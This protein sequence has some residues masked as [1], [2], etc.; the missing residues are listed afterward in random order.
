MDVADP[1]DARVSTFYLRPQGV[2]RAEAVIPRPAPLPGRGF[3]GMSPSLRPQARKYRD[4]AKSHE[5]CFSKGFRR[6]TPLLS[7]SSEK[8]PKVCSIRCSVRC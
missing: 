3:T 1:R 6:W 7:S 8:W 4:A 2:Y 5:V